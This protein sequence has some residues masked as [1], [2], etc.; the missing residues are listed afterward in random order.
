[1]AGTG[2]TKKETALAYTR[3]LLATPLA[4]IATFLYVMWQ[5]VVE[6]Q[7][8][9]R[10]FL[11]E[12]IG[13]R[14]VAKLPLGY[15]NV[16]ALKSI[17]LCQHLSANP[18]MLR[19]VRR[20]TEQRILRRL[21]NHGVPRGQVL[22]IPEYGPGEIDPHRF[23]REHVKRS[24]PCVLRGFVENASADWTLARLAERFPNTV[25]QALDKGTKKMVNTSLRQIAEDRRRNFIPQQLLLDQN[26]TFYEYFGIP[27]SHGYFPVMGRPSKPVLS[28]LILGLGAGLNANYHCEEGPNWYMAVSGSK[29]WTLIE[30]EYS[31]LLYP[32]ARGNG[33]RRFAEFS[34][35]EHGEPSDRDT[36]AL[37]EYA[38]RYE[39]DLH[40]GDVLFF[41]PW[42][43]HKTINL[44]E[45]GLGITC[46]YTAPTEISNRYFRGLQL[47]SGGFWKSCIEV[48][49]CSIRGNIA[50]L[51]TDTAHNEQE[52]TLY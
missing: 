1:M 7:L 20:R 26:P 11:I 38:P 35:D 16:L 46:R 52:S 45:E 24:I 40:P 42:M 47:L 6:Q 37:T 8:F 51:A 2:K 12:R 39:L 13:K 14:G 19:D 48:I 17:M 49:S 31:W 3:D 9:L 28:F 30:S 50:D 10:T 4:G 22:A 36:Y 23:Y 5:L 21:Q 15:G 44:D 25:V 41:P 32:A 29:H 34:A 27:R 33:M 18:D 43:W